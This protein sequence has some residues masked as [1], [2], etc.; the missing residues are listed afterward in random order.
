MAVPEVESVEG[1]AAL[2]ADVATASAAS[3]GSG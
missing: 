3:T 1:D 2:G